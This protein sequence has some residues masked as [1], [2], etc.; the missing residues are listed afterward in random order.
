MLSGGLDSTSIVQLAA[1]SVSKGNLS[2]S[3]LATLSATFGDQECDETVFIECL[4]RQI[5]FASHSFRAPEDAQFRKIGKE[6][7]VSDSPV[8]DIQ[9]SRLEMN[10]ERVRN[11]GARATLTGIG[12]DELLTEFYFLVDLAQR[13]RY[14]QLWSC[15]QDMYRIFGSPSPYT[16]LFVALRQTAPEAAKRFYR[17]IKPPQAKSLPT[18]LNQDFLNRYLDFPEVDKSIDLLFTSRMQESTFKNF[19]DPYYHLGLENWERHAAHSGFEA[20][21]PYLDR[22]LVEFVLRVPFEVR[23]PDKGRWK[24]LLR[25]AME[26][27]LPDKLLARREKTAFDSYVC[28]LLKKMLPDIKSQ[29]FDEHHWA[30]EAYIDRNQ[31]KRIIAEYEILDEFSWFKNAYP[32]WSTATFEMWCRHLKK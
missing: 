5:P 3:A 28:G 21:H 10:A 16:L 13:R 27:Q 9:C 8:V 12:G 25:R 14:R 31:V 2:K 23:V 29:L 1:D 17:S 6:F 30:S 19:L 15:C 4:T 26:G 22:E 18:W 11:L 7:A 32:V 20:R 24:H